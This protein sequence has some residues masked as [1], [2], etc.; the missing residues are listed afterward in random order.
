MTLIPAKYCTHHSPISLPS[1]SHRQLL[2]TCHVNF[3]C[4]G[5][6]LSSSMVSLFTQPFLESKQGEVGSH[7]HDFLLLSEL[8]WAGAR[9]FI[10]W[11]NHV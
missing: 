6:P 11:R 1:L 2:I 8:I 9:Q 4:S 5:S 3:H 7:I 10:L